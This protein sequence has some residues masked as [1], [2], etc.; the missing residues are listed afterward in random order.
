MDGGVKVH[1]VLEEEV[2]ETVRVDV[3]GPEEN[4]ALRVWNVISG[5]RTLRAGGVTRELEVWGVLEG[6]VVNGVVDMLSREGDKVYLTDVKTR[7]TR[8]VPS[9]PVFFRPATVQLRLYHRFLGDMVSDDLDYLKIFRRYGADPDAVFSDA[10]LAQILAVHGDVFSPLSTPTETPT[11]EPT[12]ETPLLYS[13]L[14]ALLPL[15]RSEINLT[16]PQG[17]A[18]LGSR[19]SLEYRFRDDGSHIATHEFATDDGALKGYVGDD[20]QW[21]RGERWPRGVPVEEAYKCRFCEFAEGCEWRGGMDRGRLRSVVERL[22]GE[23]AKADGL[24]DEK[25]ADE[26]GG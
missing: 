19:L 20:M 7:G 25:K 14:R 3:T 2:H 10:F 1:R 24:G 18:S 12:E 11:E 15:L 17:Q 9:D 21:W 8:K 13:T 23:G 26:A 5:L 6:E 4:M 22:R 16:F